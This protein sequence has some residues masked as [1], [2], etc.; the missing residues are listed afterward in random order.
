MAGSPLRSSNMER[1]QREYYFC[2][3]LITRSGEWDEEQEDM[4]ILVSGRDA[5]ELYETIRDERKQIR[6]KY[7]DPDEEIEFEYELVFYALEGIGVCDR[8]TICVDQSTEDGFKRGRI[9]K[10]GSMK[11]WM[12]NLILEW[13]IRNRTYLEAYQ[14]QQN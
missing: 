6:E 2:V 10:L 8:L 4:D 5:D 7:N 3:N 12:N 11:A 9:L 14:A 13:P 1:F